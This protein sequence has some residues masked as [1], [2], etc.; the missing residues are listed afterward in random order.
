MMQCV[1]KDRVVF[2]ISIYVRCIW[3]MS[4]IY[5]YQAS[6]DSDIRGDVRWGMK[7]TELAGWEYG[8]MKCDVCRMP[9]KTTK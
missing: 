5:L 3:N 1:K 8:N 4:A 2:F 9:I 7:Y 6:Y